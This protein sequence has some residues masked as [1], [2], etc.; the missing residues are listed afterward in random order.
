MLL[1]NGFFKIVIEANEA[2]PRIAGQMFG[3]NADTSK[4]DTLEKRG[5]KNSYIKRWIFLQI[6]SVIILLRI[7]DYKMLAKKSSNENAA[8]KSN[9]CTMMLFIVL[10]AA[11]HYRIRGFNADDY[12]C[13]INAATFLERKYDD[14][15]YFFAILFIFNKLFLN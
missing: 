15:K 4:F 5:S 10:T 8:A 3:Y 6:V 2:S 9:L 12:L 11:E 1:S 7:V 14:G 13:F